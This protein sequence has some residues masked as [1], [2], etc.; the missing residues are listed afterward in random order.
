MLQT[1]RLSRGQTKASAAL[2]LVLW[3]LAVF[4]LTFDLD[5]EK[6]FDS[7]H[8][9][10]HNE[11]V[12]VPVDDHMDAFTKG[13]NGFLATW[14]GAFCSFAFAY[15]EFVGAELNFKRAIRQS[16]SI[17]HEADGISPV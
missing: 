14:A 17:R 5:V 10:I 7:T 11:T 6:D 13:G 2:L 4:L 1:K 8:T 15:H 16:F 9:T 3:S 12:V